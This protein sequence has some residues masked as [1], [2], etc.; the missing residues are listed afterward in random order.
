MC[1]STLTGQLEVILSIFSLEKLIANIGYNEKNVDRCL[2]SIGL[3][4]IKRV[5]HTQWKE[6][7]RSN[8]Q[9]KISALEDSDLILFLFYRLKVLHSLQV[10]ESVNELA[11][12]MKD[13]IL[14]VKN[15]H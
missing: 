13:V 7:E 11:Q 4:S 2:M 3:R 14:N 6:R 1:L 9:V 12:I 10:V 15:T 8:R 5:R